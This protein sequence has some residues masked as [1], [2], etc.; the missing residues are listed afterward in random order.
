LLSAFCFV[1]SAFFSMPSSPLV[2]V[3]IPA[4]N[5]A[6]YLPQAIGSVLSQTCPD[7][8]LVIVDDGSTDNTAEVVK[9]FL[10]A[11]PRVRYTY[12]NNAGLSAARNTGIRQARTPFLAFLDADDE[13]E[14][15]FL[16]RCLETLRGLPESFGLV[17]CRHVP[18]DVLGKQGEYSRRDTRG[19][20]E[21]SQRELIL[22]N[23]FSPA[24]LAKRS[25]FDQAGGFEETLKSSEDRDMWIRIASQM[26]V[27]YLDEPLVLKRAHTLNMSS[28]SDRMREN[29]RKVLQKARQEQGVWRQPFFW[30][31]VAAYFRVQNAW[32]LYPEGRRG[33]AIRDVIVSLLLWPFFLHP[34]RLSEPILFRARSLARFVLRQPKAVKSKE[35]GGAAGS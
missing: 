14:P 17:G 12:Q 3:I 27:F 29:M 25:A 11:D 34:A 22:K 19:S 21:I 13:W 20:R 1:L 26:R 28:H 7:F 33:E 35:Q 30:L 32:M 9:P 10:K 5:Y 15:A 23:R 8:E 18:I 24:V 16:E 31:Q 6:R 2:T 4:Y